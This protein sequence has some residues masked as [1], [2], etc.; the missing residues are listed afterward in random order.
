MGGGGGGGGGGGFVGGR[1]GAGAGDHE[2]LKE[3]LKLHNPSLKSIFRNTSVKSWKNI[4]LN[5]VM[6]RVFGTLHSGNWN[7]FLKKGFLVCCLML[8]KYKLLHTKKIKMGK[9]F[10][11]NVLFQLLQKSVMT[12]FNQL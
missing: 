12:A 7:I 9:M 11:V 5:R 1:A 8:V 10:F 6:S 3:K 4:S 2:I